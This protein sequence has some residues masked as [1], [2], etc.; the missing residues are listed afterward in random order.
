MWSE[1]FGLKL[2]S[3]SGN[4]RECRTRQI[5]SQVSNANEA[6]S[7]SAE[8]SRTNRNAEERAPMNERFPSIVIDPANPRYDSAAETTAPM[9]SCPIAFHSGRAMTTTAVAPKQKI[10]AASTGPD[11]SPQRSDAIQPAPNDATAA[12]RNP[13]MRDAK[14][15]R[16]P[17]KAR[18]TAAMARNI[19]QTRKKAKSMI[20]RESRPRREA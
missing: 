15:R 12:K 2:G 10:S 8:N 17:A 11:D 13:A 4:T 3:G 19:E 18:R 9:K 7:A 14:R 5:T 6:D 20:A 1:T 16:R